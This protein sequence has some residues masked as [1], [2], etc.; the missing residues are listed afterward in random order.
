MQTIQPDIVVTD[1][2]SG[3]LMVVEV[4]LSDSDHCVNQA[5]AHI[6]R[7]MTAVDCSM[8]LVVAGERLVLLRDSLE[9]AN[10]ESIKMVGEAKLPNSLLPP[11]D[12][13]WRGHPHL[14]FE[15]KVQGWLENS[16]LT[17]NV[18]QL[19]DDLKELFSASVMNLLRLGDIRAGGPRWRKLAG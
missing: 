8:G 14:E 18:D 3:Y 12:E 5:I 15:S 2:D 10:G 19:P 13:Q 7:L 4:N 16:K 11:A 1:P 9:L 17:S 6:K